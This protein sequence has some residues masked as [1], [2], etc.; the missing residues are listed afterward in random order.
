[1]A[2]AIVVIGA[3][4][5]GRETLDVIAAINATADEPSWEVI[6]VVDDGPAEIQVERLRARGIRVLG[7]L[8]SLREHLP[9]HYVVG[10]GAPAVRKRIATRIDSWGGRPAILV[11]PAAVVGTQVEIG[12]GTV[13][14]GGSQIS[15]NVRLGR[16]VH[17]N[18]GAIIGHDAILE[19]FVSVNPGA[20]VSGEVLLGR[21]VLIGAG[22]TLLQ[23]LSIG[24]GS[25]VGASACVT[26]DVDAGTTVIGV[27]AREHRRERSV[28]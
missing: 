27:P 10:V 9:A 3:G 19:D 12:Q 21:E 2:D 15:T 26:K 7:G 20:I 25:L 6:G 11:H 18:P 13:V 8:E 17:I 14:C 22:A 16:H 23:Q 28:V 5:F 24:P 1:M 4:G